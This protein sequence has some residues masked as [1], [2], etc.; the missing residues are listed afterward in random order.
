M[1]LTNKPSSRRAAL[2]FGMQ[3][4][5]LVLGCASLRHAFAQSAA[6]PSKPIRLI[7]PVG[8]GGGVTA[9]HARE[10]R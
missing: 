5:A 10:T 6:W 3:L 9:N 8:P 2:G 4:S 7:V 1:Q